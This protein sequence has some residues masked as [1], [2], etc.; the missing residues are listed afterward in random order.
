MERRIDEEHPNHISGAHIMG[1]RQ[2]KRLEE[3]VPNEVHKF[4]SPKTVI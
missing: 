3:Q 4:T 2:T 1:K